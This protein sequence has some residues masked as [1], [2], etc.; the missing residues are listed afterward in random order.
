MGGN[1][2]AR[3]PM[4]LKPAAPSA[5]HPPPHQQRQPPAPRSVA[6][7]LATMRAAAP[8]LPLPLGARIQTTQGRQLAR[9]PV[10]IKPAAPSSLPGSLPAPNVLPQHSQPRLTGPVQSQP[11]V[12]RTTSA[13]PP[14]AAAPVQ[15]VPQQLPQQPLKP[16]AGEVRVGHD[17]HR[18]SRLAGGTRVK[19]DSGPS[20]CV[21]EC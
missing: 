15:C 7:L 13:P 10:A 8:P 12:A 20:A 18:S 3:T 21:D 17:S 1:K 14:V 19:N 6:S 9:T 2:L 16:A 4:A 5:S 11:P